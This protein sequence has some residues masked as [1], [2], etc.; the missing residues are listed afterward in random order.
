M[1]HTKLED[2]KEAAVLI[3]KNK[4]GIEWNALDQTL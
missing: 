3:M 4:T 1:P 2:I